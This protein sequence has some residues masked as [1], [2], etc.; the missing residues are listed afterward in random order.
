VRL[1]TTF[2][3]LAIGILGLYFFV[4]RRSRPPTPPP[5]A[6]REEA[7][8]EATVPVL[9]SEK[10]E[11]ELLL[12]PFHLD[13]GRSIWQRRI[14]GEALSETPAPQFLILWV[15]NHGAEEV[16][17][18]P[19][20]LG[21]WKLEEAPAA[22]SLRGGDDLQV[23]NE[24]LMT[25][26]RALAFADR[27]RLEPRSFRRFLVVAPPRPS[28]DSWNGLES[29]EESE[30]WSPHEISDRDLLRYERN[31]RGRWSS[32]LRP[33]AKPGKLTAEKGAETPPEV[34]LQ[35]EGDR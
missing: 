32:M 16:V 23:S 8:A 25:R 15:A 24:H 33:R 27:H 4:E 26:W 34:E 22:W 6:L 30:V 28:F 1:L 5:A 31:P 3:I 29:R 13:T 12:R 2:G 18:G 19:D 7:R 20:F 11:L 9:H 17:L 14:W 21:S 10:G 35:S